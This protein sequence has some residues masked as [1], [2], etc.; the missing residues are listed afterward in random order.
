MF[1]SMK[2]FKLIQGIYMKNNNKFFYIF[3][4]KFN[5]YMSNM[6]KYYNYLN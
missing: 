2:N 6:V 1:N 3:E 5:E 4:I